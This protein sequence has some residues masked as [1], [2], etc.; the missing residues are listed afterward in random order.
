MGDSLLDEVLKANQIKAEENES[1]KV[2]I[3]RIEGEKQALKDHNGILM[4]KIRQFESVEANNQALE[5]ENQRSAIENER[6]RSI[7]RRNP[8]MP[9]PVDSSIKELQS[10]IAFL[11]NELDETNIQTMEALRLM[12]RNLDQAKQERVRIKQEN[13]VL[14]ANQEIHMGVIDDLKGEIL[15][16]KMEKNQMEKDFTTTTETYS[17]PFVMEFKSICSSKPVVCLPPPSFNPFHESGYL[18]NYRAT[19]RC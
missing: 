18:D 16:E 10:T 14:Q 13:D 4:A 9:Q 11:K 5:A 2:H 12:A 17:E 7:I 19:T 8:S 3:K 1:L 6:L 15:Q